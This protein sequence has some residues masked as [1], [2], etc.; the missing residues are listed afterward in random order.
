MR[1]S[2]LASAVLLTITGSAQAFTP[3]EFNQ[4]EWYSFNTLCNS[5]WEF[6]ERMRRHCV[7][8]QA[9]SIYWFKKGEAFRWV[10]QTINTYGK[11]VKVN[12]DK[13]PDR[14]IAITGECEEKWRVKAGVWD[15]A[16]VKFCFQRQF[17]EW[18]SAEKKA[19]GLGP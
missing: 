8:N 13:L 18:L 12:V 7:E 4:G 16:M 6:D 9:R 2:L 5:K 10:A 11:G 1:E 19:Q 3:D 14:A 15:Y 17:E